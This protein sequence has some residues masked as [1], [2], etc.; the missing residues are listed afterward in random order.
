MGFS[1]KLSPGVRVRVS[2]RGVRTSLGPR[3]A[4]LHIGGGRTAISSGFGPVTYSTTLSGG[5]GTASVNRAL[6]SYG[7]AASVKEIEARRLAEILVGIFELHREEF[8]EAAPPTA[9]E[10]IPVDRKAVIARH[11]AEATKGIGIFARSKRREAVAGADL[12]AEEEIVSMEDKARAEAA[13]LQS[14]LDSWWE[15]LIA[16]DPDVV[17]ETLGAAFGDNQAAAAAVGLDGD[18]VSLIVIV[19]SSDAIPERKPDLTPSGNL[20]L[21]KITKRELAELYMEML[22][23]YAL[24]T[25]KECFAVA[26]S[27]RSARIAAVRLSPLD[28]YGNQH[29]EVVL[30]VRFERAKLEG[31]DWGRADSVMITNDAGSELTYRTK[32]VVKELLPLDLTT[33]PDLA[34]LISAVDFE[35]LTE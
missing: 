30:T 11:R 4:R 2:S 31:I 19:P 18:E 7:S 22:C 23:G 25:V 3:G 14:D 13:V 16:N 33:N 15:A 12:R 24:V 32:G 8:P 27:V 34:S 35:S 1:I 28:S 26:P 21:K 20:T 17:L 9:P 10:P 29:P 6:G 5:R